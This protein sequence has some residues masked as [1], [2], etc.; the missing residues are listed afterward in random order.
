MNK[1]LAGAGR[2]VN[3]GTITAR[4]GAPDGNGGN[5]LFDGLN[6]LGVTGPDPGLQDRSGMGTGTTG[7][8]TPQ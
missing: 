8:F 4:G 5:V 6:A 1:N 2:V 3:N 7:S